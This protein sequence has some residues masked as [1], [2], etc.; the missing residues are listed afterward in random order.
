MNKAEKY[1]LCWR[2]LSHALETIRLLFN[3]DGANWESEE[4]KEHYYNTL[5]DAV[6]FSDMEDKLNRKKK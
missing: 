3:K 1:N 4:I 6:W 2:E 5:G